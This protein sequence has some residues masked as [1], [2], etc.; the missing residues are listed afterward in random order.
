MGGSVGRS[1]CVCVWGGERA[2]RAALCAALV[3]LTWR[4]PSLASAQHHTPGSCS[5][6]LLRVQMS[7][8]W[9]ATHSPPLSRSHPPHS[10]VGGMMP[11]AATTHPACSLMCP[12]AWPWM[13]ASSLH[14][15]VRFESPH[16]A[17]FW[18]WCG[19]FGLHVPVCAESLLMP[20]ED[21]G[22]HPGGQG[23]VWSGQ[24]WARVGGEGLLASNPATAGA[25]ACG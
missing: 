11:T 2:Q 5:H 7:L 6:S 3:E 17:P 24:S 8:T 22:Q 20:E 9:E 25:C 23:T 21:S 4:P 18:S 1:V 15:C 12:A 19:A 13:T 10:R 14:H 16:P